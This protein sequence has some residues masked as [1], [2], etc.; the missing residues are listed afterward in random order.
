MG[1]IVAGAGEKVL[2]QLYAFGINLGIAFQIQDDY[3]DAFGDSKTFGKQV[4]G[5]IIENKKTF[6]YLKALELASEQQQKE[7]V[8][9][10]SIEP[11]DPTEKISSIKEIFVDSGAAQNTRDEMVRYSEKAFEI[12]AKLPISDEKKNI[13]R[14]FGESLMVREV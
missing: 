5:D 3:L 8:D 9:L 12:L 2:D 4:G 10:F 7:L 1:G 11:K 6:L 14:S 13:F